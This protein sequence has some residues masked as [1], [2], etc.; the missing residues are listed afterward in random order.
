MKKL[1]IAILVIIMAM[2]LV[3]CADAPTTENVPETTADYY[4]YH[5]SL[6]DGTDVWRLVYSEQKIYLWVNTLDNSVWIA[7]GNS[8]MT[9]YTINGKTVFWRGSM[10]ETFSYDNL[11]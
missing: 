10:E 9:P 6:D 8:S 2:S 3:G 4:E 7:N 5:S 11:K 1:I